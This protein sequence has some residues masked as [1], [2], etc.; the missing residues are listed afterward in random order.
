MRA[1]TEKSALREAQR[2]LDGRHAL[3]FI[4]GRILFGW[5]ALLLFAFVIFG[6]RDG[7]IYWR[8]GG[9]KRSDSPLLF[10]GLIVVQCLIAIY[11]IRGVFMRR[12]G[13]NIR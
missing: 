9:P 7:V 5:L 11:A 13:D 2:A 10:W 12:H 1:D 4:G 8:G 3:H 6:L